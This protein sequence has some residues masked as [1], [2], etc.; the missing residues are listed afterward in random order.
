MSATRVM[1]AVLGAVVA[2]V[3][4]AGAVLA[5]VA[6]LPSAV[7]PTATTTPA[8]S[9]L[10][11]SVAAASPDAPAAFR[12]RTPFTSCGTVQLQ[13]GDP[14]PATRIACLVGGTTA[15]RE[16]VV[17]SPTTDG[18][19]IV[20]YFRVGPGIS[21]VQLFTDA[22]ADPNGGGWSRTT[23]TSG[24]IDQYGACA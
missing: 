23:C 13:Q 5:F 16:L 14:I 7:Q 3:V 9:D 2:L 22:T 11:A 1:L 24:R 18:D 8:G 15:G 12:D 6:F 20:R 4:V 21:G 17:T 10:A 19:P